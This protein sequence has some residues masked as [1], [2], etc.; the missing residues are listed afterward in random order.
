MLFF[1][2]DK[3][4]QHFFRFFCGVGFFLGKLVRRS[5]GFDRFGK[6]AHMVARVEA[7]YDHP[8]AVFIQES[9]GETLI[10]AASGAFERI[11][12][13]GVYRLD[14]PFQ[15]MLDAEKIF[16]EL[17]A[18]IFQFLDGTVDIGDGIIKADGVRAGEE[19]VELAIHIYDTAR[20]DESDYS[21]DSQNDDDDGRDVG[22]HNCYLKIK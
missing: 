13:D 1:L 5:T 4:S 14:A 19:A 2:A 17:S 18:E 8:V 21:N 20:H 15:A 9:R 16:F 12:S 7:R 3:I 6:D 10:A 22:N 11:E